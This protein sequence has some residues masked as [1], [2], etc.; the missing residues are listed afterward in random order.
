MK[1]ICFITGT[2]AEFGLLQPLIDRFKKE[3]E[4][5]VQ[6]IVTGMH[7]SPEFGLTY[8]FI[9]EDGYNIDDKIEILLS[10]DTPSGI[11]KSMGL[12][13]IGMADTF[14][15][16]NPDLF[17]VLGDRFEMLSVVS[18]AL[19]FKIPVA[20]LHGG[21]VTEGA[22]DDS[23]RHAITKMSYF[24]FVSTE[25]YRRRVIQLGENP[26]RVFNVGAI[27]IDNIVNRPL[28]SRKELSENIDFDVSNDFYLVTFHPETLS[29]IPNKEQFNELLKALIDSNDKKIIFTKANTD[30]EGK[31]INNMID[32]FVAANPKKAISYSSMG[33]LKYLSAMKYCSAVIGNSSSGIIEAP[34]LKVPTINVGDRQKG[35]VAA[36]SV[37]DCKP[38]VLDIKKALK[39]VSSDKFTAQLRNIE[40]PY[41]DGSTAER[42][43]SILREVSFPLKERKVFYNQ[44]VDL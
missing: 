18:A 14:N 23:I 8:Q 15:R 36:A 26:K 25:E 41:G 7:L 2:R 11:V 39:L 44:K 22:Y 6:L 19:I 12:A 3:K 34:S 9:E 21:E 35:R 37:I 33:Q 17:V 40:N 27:G 16:L 5:L 13:Q 43:V 42:I 1:K 20:H 4:W 28:L 38:L 10:S 30:T 32:K 31:L 29:D 24:H